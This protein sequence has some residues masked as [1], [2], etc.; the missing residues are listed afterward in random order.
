MELGICFHRWTSS[1]L[2]NVEEDLKLGSVFRGWTLENATE[3][4]GWFLTDKTGFH[5]DLTDD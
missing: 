3:D 5:N 4:E 2:E 1:T